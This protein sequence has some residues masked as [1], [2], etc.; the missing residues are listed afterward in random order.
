MNLPDVQLETPRLLLRIPQAQDLDAMAGFLA[1][2]EA[3]RFIGGVQ[4]RSPAW[5]SLTSQIGSWAMQGFAMFS[6]IEKS[7]GQWV[8][9]IGPWQPA[10][11]PGTEVGWGVA[12]QHWGKGYAPEAARAATDWAFEQLGWQEVIHTIDPDNHS[13]KAVARKLGSVYLRMGALPEPHHEKPVE[14]WGQSRAQWLARPRL[15]S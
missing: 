4:A 12:R 9:R 13:S 5:R 6:A 15:Q 3:T 7:S 11:W 8:G 10:E 2:E 1:D 14:I